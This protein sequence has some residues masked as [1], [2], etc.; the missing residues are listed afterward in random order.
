ME[1]IKGFVISNG[2]D[3]Y[4]GRNH[5][6]MRPDTS[7]AWLFSK[8]ELDALRARSSEFKIPAFSVF[9]AHLELPQ[10]W[11]VID[12]ASRQDF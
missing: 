3:Q 1:T 4:L 7:D 10:K 2:N 12:F 9:S 11:L 5:C 8:E 6:W